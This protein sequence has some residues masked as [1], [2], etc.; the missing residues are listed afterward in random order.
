MPRYFFN[1]EGEGKIAPDLVGKELAN[2]QAARLEAERLAA[3]VSL[4]P[5]IEGKQ[6]AFDWIEVLDEYERAV[7][8]LP[9]SGVA[10]DPSRL[11]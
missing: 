7:V 8:R 1:F 3:D 11:S 2:D 4:Q 6:P 5:R 10:K 9:V